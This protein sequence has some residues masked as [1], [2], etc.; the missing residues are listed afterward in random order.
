MNENVIGETLT[1]NASTTSEWSK[2]LW[3]TNMHLILEVWQYVLTGYA[4]PLLQDFWRCPIPVKLNLFH[5]TQKRSYMFY[6]VS[7]HWDGTDT[8][9]WN[10]SLWKPRPYFNVKMSSYQYRKSHCGDRTVVRSSYLHNGI[11]YTG[12]MT[13]LYWIKALGINYCTGFVHLEYFGFSATTDKN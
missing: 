2:I 6:Q 7:H 1:G 3:P 8:C 4:T 9:S 11:S 13:S 5:W 12:K 10:L